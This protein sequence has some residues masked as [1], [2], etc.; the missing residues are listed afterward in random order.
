MNT[1]Y[2][3]YKK[4][5]LL[6]ALALLLIL[7]GCGGSKS[8]SAMDH[9][10][11]LKPMALKSGQIPISVRRAALGVVARLRGDQPLKEAR[12]SAPPSRAE[13]EVRPATL[14]GFYLGHLELISFA[15]NKKDPAM[16]R[17][18]VLAH[19]GDRYGRGLVLNCSMIYRLGKQGVEVTAYRAAPLGRRKVQVEPMVV[20][21]DDLP[22]DVLD[23]KKQLDWATFYL[24]ARQRD[25]LRYK[26]LY[27]GCNQEMLVFL[28]F[29]KDRTPGG[30]RVVL[31][32]ADQKDG[33]PEYGID[34]Y[35][36]ILDFDG[37]Q[38]A[39]TAGPLMNQAPDPLWLKLVL[40]PG[41][42]SDMDPTVLWQDNLSGMWP[43][44]AA[45]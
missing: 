37:W 22:P 45:K 16:R 9:S 5:A 27:E 40:E 35:S 31:R 33:D 1:M 26:A 20:M 29:L 41:G 7:T 13:S 24:M 30:S 17:A 44:L 32:L 43:K 10:Q 8:Q 2:S 15:Q 18:R 4:A 39:L 28:A 36:R 34:E 11:A 42:S 21:A 6:T 12:V 23:G 38:V 3:I 14:Q 25:L 19:L